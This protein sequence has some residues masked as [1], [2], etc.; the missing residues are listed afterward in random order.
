MSITNKLGQQQ[1][2]PAA[3]SL[4]PV[5]RKLPLCF[6]MFL[7]VFFEF[8]AR[9]CIRTT[10]S[11]CCACVVKLMKTPPLQIWQTPPSPPSYSSPWLD[12]EQGGVLL[13]PMAAV[14]G[15]SV[16]FGEGVSIEHKTWIP[17]KRLVNDS[18]QSPRTNTIY[19][20]PSWDNFDIL[21]KTL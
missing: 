19:N 16:R 17:F 12:S 13:E 15:V 5:L 8:A 14:G 10:F 7:H 1:A 2:F 11:K 4:F 18:Y 21:L 9:L 6:L 3:S 20:C